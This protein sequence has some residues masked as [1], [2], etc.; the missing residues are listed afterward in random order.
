MV[1][2]EARLTI[3]CAPETFLEFAMDVDRYARVD[4]KLRRVF[5]VRRRP[6]LTEFKFQPR[7]PGMNLPEPPTVARMRLVDGARID[8]ALAPL[9][10]NIP[11]RLVS[12]YRA[13]FSCT[14]VD[15]RTTVTRTV[16]YEFNPLLR[17][18]FEPTLSRTLP[19]SIERE[20][21]LAKE[22]LEGA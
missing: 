4:D 7:L 17:W 22:I 14:A 8:I 3:D 19:E 5:W 20:L 9:P 16:S 13:G 2:A 21:R 10:R 15:G 11:N 1:M 12:R 18:L 6:E